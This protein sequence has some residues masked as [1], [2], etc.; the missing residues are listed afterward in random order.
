MTRMSLLTLLTVLLNACLFPG[1]PAPRHVALAI[2]PQVIAA[3][4]REYELAVSEGVERAMCL[5]GT[6]KKDTLRVIIAIPPESVTAATSSSVQYTCRAG[7][8]F[9]G[10]WHTHLPQSDRR[11]TLLLPSIIDRAES[12]GLRIFMV[13]V[14]LRDSEMLVYTSVGPAEDHLLWDRLTSKVTGP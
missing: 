7:E 2:S 1:K 3:G 14:S 11:Y 13:A 6:M 4:F 5:Y 9:L 12:R 10:T 8:F